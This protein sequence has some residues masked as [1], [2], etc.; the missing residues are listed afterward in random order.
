MHS[1]FRAAVVTAVALGCA[2]SAGAQAL[3]SEPVTLAGGR[4]TLGGDVSAS[5]GSDDPGFF[6]Y[7]DY[8]HSALRLFRADLSGSITIS[9][10]FAVLGEI[11]D[12][13]IDTL[14]AYAFYLRIRPWV[15][16]AL[17]IQAGRVPP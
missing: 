11:R 13:N 17:D 15:D 2:A 16:R 7:T 8:E 5:V 3:R 10:H 12:E 14:R 1:V 6:N 9:R 4:V